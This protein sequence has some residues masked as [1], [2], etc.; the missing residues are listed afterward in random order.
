MKWYPQI[1]Q[2]G[3]CDLN[4]NSF[5]LYHEVGSEQSNHTLMFQLMKTFVYW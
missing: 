3:H 5:P 2:K 4:S 1:K